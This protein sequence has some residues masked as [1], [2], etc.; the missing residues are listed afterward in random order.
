MTQT[1]EPFFINKALLILLRENRRIFRL[2]IQ[3][4]ITLKTIKSSWL[5]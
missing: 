2:F 1:I 3:Y 4:L 5:N